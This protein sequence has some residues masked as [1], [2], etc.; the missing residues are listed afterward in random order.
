MINLGRDAAAR[1][2]KHLADHLLALVRLSV[3]LKE[4]SVDGAADMACGDGGRVAHESAREAKLKLVMR[5][6]RDTMAAYRLL[7]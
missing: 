1:V 7:E 4:E 6:E 5:L 2:C 3:L